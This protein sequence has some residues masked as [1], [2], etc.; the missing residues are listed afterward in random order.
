[1][2][3]GK[4]DM[5]C[6]ECRIIDYCCHGNATGYAICTDSRF[7]DVDEEVYSKIADR[8]TFE[9][10]QHCEKHETLE[11]DDDRESDGC[12]SWS[13]YKAKQIADF[14][15]NKLKEIAE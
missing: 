5:H 1:M 14:V 6:G 13:D 11:C 4:L 9:P 15:A 10:F 3:I 12:D 8:A 7:K 2:K